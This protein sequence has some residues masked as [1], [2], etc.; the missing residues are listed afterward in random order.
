MFA[1]GFHFQELSSIFFLVIMVYRERGYQC[2]DNNLDGMEL[3]RKRQGQLTRK[4][5]MEIS[6]VFRQAVSSVCSIQSTEDMMCK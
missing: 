4:Y 1:N 2:S 5:R 3:N 6:H